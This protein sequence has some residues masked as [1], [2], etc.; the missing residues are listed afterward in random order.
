[1][2]PVSRPS[3][4]LSEE[5]NKLSP[6]MR[7]LLAQRLNKK[8][9]SVSHDAIPRLSNAK[10][11]GLFPLSFSQER[12]WFLEQL[13][14]GGS[15]YT[16]AL[17]Y[18]LCGVLDCAALEQSLNEIIARHEVLRTVFVYVDERPQQKVLPKLAVPLPLVDLRDIPSEEQHAEALRQTRAETE[19]PFD[20][21]TGPMLRV[22]LFRL[23]EQ[24]HIMVLVIHHIISDGWSAGIFMRELTALYQAYINRQPSPLPE[25][26]IQYVDYAV[27]QRRTVQGQA[28]DSQLA[29]WR[30]QL[31]GTTGALDLPTDRPRLPVETHA[32]AIRRMEL[33]PSLTAAIRALNRR[34][35]T[36]LFMTMLAAFQTLLYRYTRQIDINVGTA[37]SSRGRLE[38]EPLIG[39]LTNTLVLRS[40]LSGEPSFR[41]LLRRV[42]D[43]ALGAYAHQDL[44]F[45]K[46]VDALQ[47]GRDLS[48]S[49]L[50][51]VMLVFH[52][53]PSEMLTLPGL[54]LRFW[55]CQATTAKFDLTLMFW[56]NEMSLGMLW[57]YNTDLFDAATID[58]MIG[59]FQVLLEGIVANPDQRL[60][61]LPLLT[62][63]ERHQLLVE[64]NATG[65]EYPK[66]KRIHE[67]FEAQVE[68]TPE[69]VA[70]TFG[71]QQ[72][73]YREL[74]E[75][76]NQ[77]AHYLNKQGV[78]PD[79]LVGICVERSLEMV[80]GL[81]GIIKAGGA[82]VPLDPTYPKERLTY[83]LE[84]AKPAILLTQERLQQTIPV[85]GFCLDSQWD[86]LSSYSCANPPNR[87]LPGNLAYVIYTS[88]STGKPKGVGVDHAGIR[89]RL[90]WMQEAYKLTATD[91][92]L[93]KTP[94]SFDVSVWEFFW[95]LVYGATLVVA[96]PGGHQDTE[97][98]SAIIASQAITTL[99]FVPPMLD[100][101]LSEVNP[102]NCSSLRQVICSGQ[103]LPLELQQCFFAKLPHVALHNLY[104]PTEASVDVTFWQCQQET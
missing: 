8:K 29:Y 3:P 43:T 15:P 27:W 67:L 32:G 81:L 24:D 74:N 40:D 14:S 84:D 26:P 72:L 4:G 75:R 104:G 96:E 23:G 39:F 41:N 80:V 70:V 83:M 64:W 90:Q 88:G 73:T 36:T 42:R 82:Y 46:L 19:R 37:I 6:E 7:E 11:D 92:V 45:E 76:A 89:N 62:E 91:R 13:E 28:L 94:F 79:V 58:R 56:E 103:A 2:E 51:Q 18:H 100:A 5:I 33:S 77:L 54:T 53:A 1:M 10:E 98:L 85:I 101:F 59:H 63:A 69:A 66:D 44:P 68:K 34:E 87:A 17:G 93:Q 31:K 50:F 95:P 35:G 20:L 78:G 71:D 102:A 48:R 38:T 25:L 52:N 86:T 55:D 60:A 21:T 97:Y 22:V 16:T 12:S 61:D 65:T 47:L 57:E 49:P 99:H 9:Q 30:E